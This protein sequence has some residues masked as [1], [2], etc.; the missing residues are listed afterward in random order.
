MQRR[1]SPCEENLVEIAASSPHSAPANARG[2]ITGL[3]QIIVAAGVTL[4]YFTNYGIGAHIPTGPMIWRI[5]FGL[6]LIP[7]GL[8][9][10]GLPFATESPRWLARK[11]RSAEALRALAFLRR[12]TEDDEEV[13]AELAEIEATVREEVES[14]AGFRQAVAEKGNRVSALA[15]PL[16]IPPF[17]CYTPPRPAMLMSTAESISNSS[18]SQSPL[19]CSSS[20]NGAGRQVPI[21]LPH[22]IT[23]HALPTSQ[24]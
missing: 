23:P 7:C 10:L 2:R 19:S 9:A 12:R 21:P 11:G 3:F 18:V 15:F 16:K 8:M 24:N 13:V 4:S 14:R 6:Q 22:S 5:A 1:N 20:N 17:C